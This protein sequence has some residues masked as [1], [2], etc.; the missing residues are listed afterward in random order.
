MGDDL[1]KYSRNC[2]GSSENI[3][4]A[5]SYQGKNNVLFDLNDIPGDFENK[6]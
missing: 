1:G 5:F 6:L 4:L 3:L 2:Q